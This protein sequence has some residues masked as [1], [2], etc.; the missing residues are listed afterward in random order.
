MGI[1]AFIKMA[2]KFEYTFCIASISIVSVSGATP[3]LSILLSL[4]R[5]SQ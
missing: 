5:D 1:E 3:Y 4:V 2:T